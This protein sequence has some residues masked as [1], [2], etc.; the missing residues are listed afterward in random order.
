[1]FDEEECDMLVI[2]EQTSS[3]RLDKK[4]KK[5]MEIK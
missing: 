2:E 3:Y 4:K 1:M 5:Y